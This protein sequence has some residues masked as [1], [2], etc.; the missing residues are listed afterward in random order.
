MI[1]HFFQFFIFLNFYKTAYGQSCSGQN[2]DINPD[3]KSSHFTLKWVLRD[4]LLSSYFL[5][6]NDSKV[7]YNISASNL[8]NQPFG[9]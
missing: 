8:E 5:F 2:L 6:K 4:L 1:F 9:P 3:L 7:S